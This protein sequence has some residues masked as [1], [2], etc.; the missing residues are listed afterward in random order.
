MKLLVTVVLL[1]MGVLAL[2]SQFEQNKLIIKP[3]L[4]LTTSVDKA[5]YCDSRDLKLHLKLKYKNVG[6][7]AVILSRFAATINRYRVA[8]TVKALE[9]GVFELDPHFFFDRINDGSGSHLLKM[10]DLESE[11]FVVLRPGDEFTP[12]VLKTSVNLSLDCDDGDPC[13]RPGKHILQT[14]F[15]VLTANDAVFAELQEK[16]RA[17][18]EFYRGFILSQPMEFEVLRRRDQKVVQCR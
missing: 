11:G 1:S 15:E 9:A 6:S 2:P 13:L 14:R 7:E 17:Q 18:G 16:W 10:K 4:E 8:R 3:E 12:E 5:E